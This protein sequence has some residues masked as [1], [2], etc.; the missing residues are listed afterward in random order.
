MKGLAVVAPLSA[1]AAL[2]LCS[3]TQPARAQGS[4]GPASLVNP[5]IGTAN[6]GNTFPGAVLPFGMVSFSPEELPSPPKHSFPAGGYEY[7]ATTVR[8]FSLTH[9]SGAGCAGSGD[10]LFMP[11]SGDVKESPALNPRDVIYLSGFRHSDEHAAAGYYSVRLESGILAELS[12]TLRTGAARFTYPAGSTATML[13]RSADNETYSTDSHVT[14]DPARQQVSGSLTSGNFCGSGIPPGYSSYYTIYFVAHFDHA[15]RAFGT[16]KDDA[17]RAGSLSS[18]GGTAAAEARKSSDDVRAKGSGAYVSFD[19]AAGTVLQ[20]RVGISYVSEENAEANLRAESPAGTFF[21]TIRTRAH[22]AWNGALGRIA[23]KGGTRDQQTVFY[24]ALYHALLHMNLASDVNGQYRGMDQQ[25]HQVTRPQSA[26]YANFSGWDVYRSQVQLVTLLYP[27]IGSDMAQSL[28]NQAEQWGCW[29]RWTHNSGAPNVMNGDPSASAIAAIAAFGGDGFDVKRAYESLLDAATTPHERRRCSRPHLEQWLTQHYLTAASTKHDTSVAD[30]LESSAADFALSQLAA[31][32][33]DKAEEEALLRR[34]QYWKNLFNPNATPLEGYLQ[35]RNA[36]GTWKSFDPASRDGFVEGTGA[37]Y[38]WMVPFNARGLFTLMGGDEKA[39]QRLD[40]FFRDAQGNW[41]LTTGKLHPGLD[42]E[43]CVGIPWL[44]DFSG[45]PYK[46]QQTVRAI[47]SALWRNAPDGIPGNDDLGEM[48][49]WYV[50]AA[51]G[52]Y[53]EIPGR[54]E[55]VLTS[56]LFAEAAIRRPTGT[57]RV[58][59]HPQSASSV[60]IQSLRV[61]G[62]VWQR[63]WLP[64]SFV[65]QGGALAFTLSD[66]PNREWGASAADAPPSFDVR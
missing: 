52:M 35:P 6:S 1:L 62:R 38:L 10:F 8:G 39:N 26:Q 56:P 40:G 34:A 22:V 36:D 9:L 13:I 46:T 11:V 44:Y 43:P 61:N 64:A 12:A 49:S 19:N 5:L 50:W 65:R 45:E 57:I 2:A 27:E 58:E 14:I 4:A 21:G 53:P 66:K 41:E 32:L 29:S 25:T 24:T 37:Q 47:V 3:A 51:L 33:G 48:S 20:V 7:N 63:P 23:V 54:A 31:M 28:L 60:Y 16:W 18:A 55:L 59:A 42:N 17:V 15:F 30:T